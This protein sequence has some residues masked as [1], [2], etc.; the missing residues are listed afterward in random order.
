MYFDCITFLAFSQPTQTLNPKRKIARRRMFALFG[1]M[2]QKLML[3]QRRLE[4]ETN[5][6]AT[7]PATSQSDSFPL[8]ADRS[9]L[10]SENRLLLRKRYIFRQE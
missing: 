7:I 10:S 1:L 2:N 6:Y 8:N 5:R 4:E 3:S 9:H